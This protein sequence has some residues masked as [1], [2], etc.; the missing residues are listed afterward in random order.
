MEQFGKAVSHSIPT[1]V[2][3]YKS[4]VTY[5]VNLLQNQRG[6]TL[7]QRNYHE[8]IIRSERAYENI[9]SYILSN[10][11]RWEDDFGHVS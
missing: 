1:L 8:K 3:A 4:A 6:A 5:A 10:P 9:C 11:L 7:W 2:R